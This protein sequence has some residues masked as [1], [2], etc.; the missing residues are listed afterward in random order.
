MKLVL[1]FVQPFKLDTVTLELERIPG[2]PGMS[3]AAVRGFGRDRATT[4]Q[5]GDDAL[6]D[7]ADKLQIEAVVLDKQVEDV[8]AAI[9]RA[10]HTGRYGDG[11]IFVLPVERSFRIATMTEGR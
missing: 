10:A 11:M 7:F 3:V 1:A 9:A 2:F 6:E 4:S 5:G 8:V